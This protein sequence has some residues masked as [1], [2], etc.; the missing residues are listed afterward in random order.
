MCF[1]FLSAVPT[2]FEIALSASHMKTAPILIDG[3]TTFWATLVHEH[4]V[5]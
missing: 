5:H 2:K 3:Y 1:V 4:I